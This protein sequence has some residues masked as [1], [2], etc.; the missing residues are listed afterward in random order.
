MTSPIKPPGST[1]GAGIPEDAVR[2]GEPRGVSGESFRS[3]LDGAAPEAAAAESSR[4]VAA[5][6]STQEASRASEV[7]R[8]AADLRTG[9]ID[10]AQAIDALVAR[11]L[12]SGAAKAL[13]PAQRT[14]LEAYLRT[15]LSEDPS[16]VALTKD[17]TRGD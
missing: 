11:A 1:P 2:P 13:P 10:T 8:L 15:T 4:D 12:E 9:R 3:T 5:A 17:L 6:Q 16:L 14:E 7:T